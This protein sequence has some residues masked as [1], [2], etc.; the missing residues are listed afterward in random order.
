MRDGRRTVAIVTG[1]A[2][3][4]GAAEASRLLES[5]RRVVANDIDADRLA[6]TADSLGNDVVPVPGDIC[7]NATAQ[8]LLE[9][10]TSDGQFLDV[11]VNNAGAIHD[12]MVFNLTDEDWTRIVQINL[13]GTFLL[14]REAARYWRGRAK[15]TGESR[16]STLINTTSRAGLMGN[17]GQANYAAAK[18]GVAAL[19]QVMS[20]EL[21]S[22]GVRCNAIAPRAYTSMMRASFGEF[23]ADEEDEWSADHVARFV[24][25]L[26]SPAAEDINGQVFLVQGRRV[27]RVRP[28]EFGAAAELDYDQG[29][30]RVREQMDAVLEGFPPTLP[31]LKIGDDLPLG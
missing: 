29:S 27:S 10:A 8:E 31:A 7:E 14:S 25:F 3:G 12:R 19:T 9:T 13:R 15:S 28:W 22:Y 20:R 18:A 24:V 30:P 23:A 21:R 4:L 5:R 6:R 26:C 16:R 17:P 2:G 11:V 1:A